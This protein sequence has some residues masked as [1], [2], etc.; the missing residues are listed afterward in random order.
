M[1]QPKRK[2]VDFILNMMLSRFCVDSAPELKGRIHRDDW[3]LRLIEHLQPSPEF[4]AKFMAWQKHQ[5]EWQQKH[6]SCNMFAD[7]LGAFVWW[8]Y[9]FAVNSKTKL[10]RQN[11][12]KVKPKKPEDEAKVR[13]ESVRRFIGDAKTLRFCYS[14][15][16]AF[17][18]APS[19]LRLWA[20]PRP[21]NKARSIVGNLCFWE[22]TH[23]CRKKKTHCKRKENL[24]PVQAA[25]VKGSL[26]IFSVEDWM[27]GTFVDV[28]GS[29]KGLKVALICI[30][31]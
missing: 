14:Y 25:E 13:R 7:S 18:H 9:L 2:C 22:F 5:L 30:F 29:V 17:N 12:W 31:F 27:R 4:T 3:I 20:W 26:D 11:I 24:P 28:K 15:L 6:H 8:L 21:P 10:V 1:E 23:L 19:I 16:V